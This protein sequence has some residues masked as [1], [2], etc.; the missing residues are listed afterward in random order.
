M[1]NVYLMDLPA[2]SNTFMGTFYLSTDNSKLF[3][4]DDSGAIVSVD[5]S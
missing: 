5:M 1:L 2:E 4:L 3:K